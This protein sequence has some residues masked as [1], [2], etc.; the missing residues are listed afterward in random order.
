VVSQTTARTMQRLLQGV[1]EAD[2]GTGWRAAIAGYTVGGKTGTT[3]KFLPEEGKYSDDDR[4]ASF[5]GIAPITEP[6]IAV[7]V[8]LDSPHGES[9]DGADL[10]FGGASAA[11]VFAAVAEAALH[12]LGVPPDVR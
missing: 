10:R 6:R 11:P 2:R 7:A 12:R 4:I 5:I 8:V 3:E 9:F 1:V